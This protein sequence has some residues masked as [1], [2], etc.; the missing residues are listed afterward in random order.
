MSDIE[1]QRV[2][3]GG[4][5]RTGRLID[6]GTLESAKF[7]LWVQLT[8]VSAFPNISM[9]KQVPHSLASQRKSYKSPTQVYCLDNPSSSGLLRSLVRDVISI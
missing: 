8:L 4:I 2:L 9:D 5:P 6:V 3:G 1:S 7:W